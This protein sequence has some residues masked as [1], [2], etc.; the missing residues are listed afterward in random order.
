MTP[1]PVGQDKMSILGAHASMHKEHVDSWE[2]R[3]SFCCA[4]RSSCSG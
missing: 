3:R 2:L 4:L 1:H